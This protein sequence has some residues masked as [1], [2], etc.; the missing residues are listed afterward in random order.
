MPNDLLTGAV[1]TE[2]SL[3]RAH[4]Q[5][6]DALRANWVEMAEQMLVFGNPYRRMDFETSLNVKK[7]TKVKRN[8]P[9]WW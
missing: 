4:E 2:E 3:R 8:L 9:E 1:L 7:K 5:L 6:A